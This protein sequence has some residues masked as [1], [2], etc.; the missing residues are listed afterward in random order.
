MKTKIIKS[1]Y[2]KSCNFLGKSAIRYGA[3][4]FSHG[5]FHLALCILMLFVCKELYYESLNKQQEY[6]NI[7][8]NVQSE[9]GE[10]VSDF[11]IQVFLKS[12][13]IYKEYGFYQGMDIGVNFDKDDKLTVNTQIPLDK[14]NDC[15]VDRKAS[16]RVTAP[17]SRIN[18]FKIE[19]WKDGI[20][21]KSNNISRISCVLPDI[22][23]LSEFYKNGECYS[24]V[25]GIF[26]SF[27]GN[28]FYSDEDNPYICFF[29]KI[30]MKYND[31][32]KGDIRICTTKSPMNYT[33]LYPTPDVIQP[34]YVQYNTPEKIQAV[35]HN[36]GVFFVADDINKGWEASRKSF[37]F[38]VLL[39]AAAAFIL[40]IIVNLIIKWRNLVRRKEN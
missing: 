14:P 5:G 28:L 19:E 38:S 8:V 7:S 30:E 3:L 20:K 10:A 32:T 36:G 21:Y 22:I 31:N 33:S 25:N 18:L 37:L 29:L 24:M 17:D 34:E 11:E 16:L 1:A 26:E 13:G 15:L 9:N 35:L 23:E 6:K 12:Q 27:Y 2:E 40:D 4:L 39:G